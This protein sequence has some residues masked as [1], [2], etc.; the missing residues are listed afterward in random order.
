MYKYTA[1]ER[2]ER[3]LESGRSSGLI[4]D[5]THPK[6]YKSGKDKTP[7]PSQTN[8]EIPTITPPRSLK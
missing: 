3:V 8:V 1:Y 4:D 2:R 6:R 5:V 7:K